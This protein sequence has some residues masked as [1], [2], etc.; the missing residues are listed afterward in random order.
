MQAL[1]VRMTADA[2]PAVSVGDRVS[3]EKLPMS[4]S[5]LEHVD[6]NV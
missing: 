1:Y 6:S 2:N 3:Y 5:A 4:V